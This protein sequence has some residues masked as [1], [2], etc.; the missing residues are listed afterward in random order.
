M[1][2][3]YKPKPLKPKFLIN[4]LIQYGDRAYLLS[5][6][7][8][9]VLSAYKRKLDNLFIENHIRILL[10]ELRTANPR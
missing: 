10:E 5:P 6:Y 7:I 2:K 3:L 9:P 1:N 4:S 8:N